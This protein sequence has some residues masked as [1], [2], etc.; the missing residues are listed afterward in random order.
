MRR[1][2]SLLVSAAAF[3]AAANCNNSAWAQALANQSY[4]GTLTLDT[5]VLDCRIEFF[6]RVPPSAKGVVG[7]DITK[8]GDATGLYVDSANSLGNVKITGYSTDDGYVFTTI[9]G[10]YF[11][12]IGRSG[13]GRFLTLAGIST[14]GD[15]FVFFGT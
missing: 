11:T 14:T 7:I 9:A 15:L 3:T 13:I 8:S 10:V 5:S 2:L 6:P 12:G 4:S 1:I